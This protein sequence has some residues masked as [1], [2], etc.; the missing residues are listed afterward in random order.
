[1]MPFFRNM[2]QKPD[3]YL[4]P[5]KTSKMEFFFENCER[6]SDVT[7]LHKKRMSQSLPDNR[8]VALFH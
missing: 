4:K 5:N 6:L 3:V 1:M 7:I 2:W 8:V